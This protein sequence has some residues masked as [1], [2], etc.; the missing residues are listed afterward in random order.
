[1]NKNFLKQ[2]NDIKNVSY[3]V[4][5]LCYSSCILN[6]YVNQDPLLKVDP[7]HP[8]LNIE[9][10]IDARYDVNKTN[11]AFDYTKRNFKL[12]DYNVINNELLKFDWVDIFKNKNLSCAVNLFYD[13][14]NAI[15][16]KYIPFKQI[17][18]SKFPVWY[19]QDLK[20]IIIKK[21]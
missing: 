7:S 11:F 13:I 17:K 9:C 5:D 2:Y 12:A 16:N 3:N 10:I 4:L 1:M 19:S 14:I 6:V 8:P 18:L 15:I 20:T 21:K